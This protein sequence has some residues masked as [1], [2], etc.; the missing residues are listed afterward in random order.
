MNSLSRSD[1]SSRGMPFSQYH[2]V[3]KRWVRSSTVWVI[4][5]GTSRTSEPSLSVSVSKQSKP[6]SGGNGPI[7]SIATESQ[8][9]SGTGKGCKGPI[10]LVVEDLLRWHSTQEGT[11]ADSR[12]LCMWASSM[13]CEGFCN[14]FRIRNDPS[15]HGPT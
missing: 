8:R 6:S 7:K 11:Y 4:V 14:F 13:N 9:P 15:C 1:I 12:S 10:S 2:L 5:H 3:K